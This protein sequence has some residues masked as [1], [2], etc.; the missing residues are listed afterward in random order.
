MTWKL[1]VMAEAV[2][3]VRTINI[4]ATNVPVSRAWCNSNSMKYGTLNHCFKDFALRDFF[5]SLRPAIPGG[6]GV[7]ANHHHPQGPAWVMGGCR[8]L[9]QIEAAL[10]R[11]A[12]LSAGKRT[13]QR[14]LLHIGGDPD[15][16]HLI[17]R[18]RR[19]RR[20]G[21]GQLLGRF[22]LPA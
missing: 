17:R 20:R 18:R 11:F 8:R 19:M 14:E 15:V 4:C 10:K 2:E 12:D 13:S 21:A 16:S 1:P 22:V 3:K 7:I 9:G 6:A 5:N